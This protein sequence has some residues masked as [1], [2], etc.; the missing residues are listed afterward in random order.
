[1]Y[2]LERVVRAGLPATSY[3]TLYLKRVRKSS[4]FMYALKRVVRAGL[5]CNI[6]RNTMLK[7]R[8]KK[9]TL[10]VCFKARSTCRLSLQH[11]TE[12]YT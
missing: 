5:A 12:H 10:Y 2:A 3:G 11:L 4:H 7:T 9:F 8:A 1:M 6:L